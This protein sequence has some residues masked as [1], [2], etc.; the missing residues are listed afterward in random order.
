MINI[1]EDNKLNILNHSCAHLFAHAIKRLY[2]TVKFWV[3]PVIEEGF[4]YDVDLGDVYLKEENFKEIEAEMKKIAKENILI[5]RIVLSKNE[6]LEIF[7]ED[8]YKLE[9]INEFVNNEI[10]SIYKQGE[11]IDICKGP[12]VESTKLLENFKLMK[13]SGAYYKNDIN[14]KMLTRIYGICFYKENELKEY[15]KFIEEA[16]SRDHRKLGKDLDLFCFS[17]LVGPGLPL[18]TQKGVTIKEELQKEVENICRK[19]GFEK[20]STPHLANIKLFETSGH[21]AKFGDELFHVSS[22]K[23]HDFVLKPVQCPGHTQIYASRPRSYKDLPIRYMESEKQYR[24][25]L[26]GAVSGLSRVYAITCEDGHSFCRIDQVKQEV[27]NMVNI[28][29]DFYTRL[30]L[31]ENHWVSLSVRDYSHPEKYIGSI[32]DWEVCEDMLQEVSNELGLNAKKCEGEAALYG[33]KLD[34]MFKDAMGREIQIPTVQLDFATPKRFDLSYIDSNGDKISPVMVHRAILGSYE[35]FMVLLIENYAGAFPLW[36]SPIQVNIIPVNKEYHLEYCNKIKDI[37]N[38]E[39]IRVEFDDSD[40][41]LNYKIR[42][43][44]LNKIPYTLIIG[45]NEKNSD[46]ISYRLLGSKDT[47]TIELEE[48]IYKINKEIKE[49]LIKIEK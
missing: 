2:P 7:I 24:A 22:E 3:G 49:R 29:K 33:P 46:Q 12:H 34:F 19:Y 26:S 9:L 30:G 5:E 37:L 42:Q 14:N 20:V 31:W 16:K 17:D 35:R 8:N 47:T 41:K 45:D 48:F 18:F 32:E 11:F 21:A 36:L 38:L 23:G 43:S 25:E 44:Y 4:Y 27:I 10:I 28:I 6:A 1:K 40:D 39:G 15:L 13:I